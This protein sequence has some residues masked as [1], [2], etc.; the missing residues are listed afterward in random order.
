[1]RLYIKF[2]LVIDLIPLLSK[3]VDPYMGE[4]IT[5]VEIKWLFFEIVYKNGK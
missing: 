2:N 5:G 3:K 4:I 1:M